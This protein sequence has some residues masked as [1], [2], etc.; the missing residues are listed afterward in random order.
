MTEKNYM[1]VQDGCDACNMAKEILKD[2][3]KNKRLILLDI[4]SKKGAELTEKHKI[5][6]VPTIINEK[7]TFQQKCFLVKDGSK[8]LCDDGSE[9]QLIKESE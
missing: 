7:D 8:M 9:K 4:N 1:I 6:T 5:E 2:N 3:I